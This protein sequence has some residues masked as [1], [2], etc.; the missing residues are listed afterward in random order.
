MS[1]MKFGAGAVIGFMAPNM[2]QYQDLAI[3]LFAIAPIPKF[4]LG[5]VARGYVLGRIVKN[6]GLLGG[7]PNTGGMEY[8]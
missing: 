5:A 1:I 8:V 2:H 6:M 3:T 7:T 4:G